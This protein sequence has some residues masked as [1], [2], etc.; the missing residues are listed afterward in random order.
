MECSIY[1]ALYI[2]TIWFY[3]PLLWRNQVGADTALE[4]TCRSTARNFEMNAAIIQDQCSGNLTVFPDFLKKFSI[5]GKIFI[6][7]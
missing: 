6:D 2:A 3:L 7:M 4:L 1:F 5:P